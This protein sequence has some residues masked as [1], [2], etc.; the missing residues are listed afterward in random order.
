[1]Q[2][3][4]LKKGFGFGRTFSNISPTL[5]IDYILAT[6]DLK[7]EQFNKGNL[8]VS[9]HYPIMADFKLIN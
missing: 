5:R 9:D 6:K 4:F 3:A 7:I 8:N 2:D 1:M